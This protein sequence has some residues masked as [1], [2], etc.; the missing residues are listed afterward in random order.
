MTA[1]RAATAKTIPFPGKVPGSP[2]GAPQAQQAP[3]QPSRLEMLVEIEGAIRR[4]PTAQAV[5]YH[6]VNDAAEILGFDQGFAARF[7]QAGKARIIAVSG[8]AQ[9]DLRA[10]ALLSASE[11]ISTLNKIKAGP[12]DLAEGAG[13]WVPLADRESNVFG[14]MIYMN[15]KPWP[16]GMA[17]IVTRLG[18]TYAHALQALVPPKRLRAVSLPRPIKWLVP[19]LLA[20]ACFIPVPLTALAPFEVVA[21]S[22]SL[23]TAPMEGVVADILVEPN[24]AVVAGQP[25]YKFDETVL[26]SEA[27]VASQKVNVA[28]ARLQTTQSAAFRDNDMKRALAVTQKDLE[29]AEAEFA[30]AKAMLAKITVAAPADGI[31]IF[32][33][34]NDWIGKPVRVGEKVMEIAAPGNVAYK[35]SLGVHDAIAL[36]QGANIRLFFDA[37]PLDAKPAKLVEASYHAQEVAGGQLAYILKAMPEQ[38]TP[39]QRIGLRGTA[40]I[41]GERV[42]LGFYLFRRPIA[43]LRQY[44]G[45]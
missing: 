43:A 9:P 15:A 1:V 3:R 4:L 34:R 10:P 40:Q 27:A 38:G 2:L 18:E 6:A 25:L 5:Y 7:D 31:V 32:A 26:R 13:F 44:L 41:S 12:L 30:Y 39:A 23:A 8:V 14:G 21:E 19:V 24:Q 45:V 28:R 37:D 33:A 16:D 20:A 11:F 35:I 17:M 29:L 42:S 36:S 22:P